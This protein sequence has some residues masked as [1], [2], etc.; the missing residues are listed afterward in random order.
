MEK[1]FFFKTQRRLQEP[2]RV[3]PGDD[4]IGAGHTCCYSSVVICSSWL[5]VYF[6]SVSSCLQVAVDRSIW[7]LRRWWVNL[8][9]HNTHN[10]LTHTQTLSVR[11]LL[12]TEGKR[13]TFQSFLCSELI[14]DP[15]IDH[16]QITAESQ[17]KQDAVWAFNEWS[18]HSRIVLQNKSRHFFSCRYCSNLFGNTQHLIILLNVGIWLKRC[19]Q[20]FIT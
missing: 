5:Q 9:E 3:S 12:Y 8:H 2:T 20:I 14:N 19:I 18:W 6:L 10:T 17:T 13:C 1:D 11:H 16:N 15:I 7:L 4:A